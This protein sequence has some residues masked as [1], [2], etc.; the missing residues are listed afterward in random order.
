[1]TPPNFVEY[2][3]WAL[4]NPHPFQG[5]ADPERVPNQ[6][7]FHVCQK[8]LPKINKCRREKGLPELYPS[9]DSYPAPAK[10]DP[11]AEA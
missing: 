2:L 1:V 5:N 9:R 11:D 4:A 10:E 6:Q 3:C 7:G 8:H